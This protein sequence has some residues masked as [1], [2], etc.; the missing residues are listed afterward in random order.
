MLLVINV[1]KLVLLIIVTGVG[2]HIPRSFSLLYVF[3]ALCYVLVSRGGNGSAGIRRRLYRARWLLALL[4][5]FSIAYVCAMLYWQI[6]AW[7]SDRLDLMNALFL[8]G[9]LFVTGLIAASLGRTACTRV[10]LAYGLGGLVYVLISLGFAHDPLLGLGQKFAYEIAVPWGATSIMNVRSVEQNVFP[11]LLLLPVGLCILLRPRQS[12]GKAFIWCFCFAWILGAY[13]T[14]ALD[15]RMGWL[16]CV[17]ASI[18]VAMHAARAMIQWLLRWKQRNILLLSSVL[19]LALILLANRFLG[20]SHELVTSEVLCDERFALFGAMLTRIHEAPW[21]GRLLRVP[22]DG[23][24]GYPH[25]V[26]AANNGN[27]A[28]AHN[29][30]LDIYFNVGVVPSVLLLAF[31]IGCLGRCSAY[32]VQL[33][34]ALEWE[35]CLRW[36]WL[37]II[38]IQ[39]MFQPLLY[40]DGLLYYFSFFIFG[41]LLAE[42]DISL[43]PRQGGAQLAFDREA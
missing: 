16:V 41:I 17:T 6:W 36:G 43:R 35:S 21:G 10:L 7:P 27:I 1:L 24:G 29:V 38:A 2:L 42:S 34:T 19:V 39:W 18:P 14:W 3:A 32:I 22:F 31:L 13:A 15:G 28:Q 25:Y 26:L 33:L 4:L 12:I 23:C 11:A 30:L 9:L 5:L 40:S 8:P 37:C 20:N